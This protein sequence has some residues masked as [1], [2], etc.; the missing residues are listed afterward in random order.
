MLKPSEFQVNEVWIAFRANDEPIFVQD[1]PYDCHVLMDAGSVYVFGFVLSPR[2]KAPDGGEVAVLLDK[3][4]RSKG[5]WAKKLIV[6]GDG[7]AE[8]VFMTYAKEK[9]LAVEVVPISQ[10]LP[11]IGEL[12]KSFAAMLMD[13][14]I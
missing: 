10:M 14:S 13:R 1:V 5:T 8:S 12:K 6:T 3:A 4:K 11:I 7:K 2:D 9:G